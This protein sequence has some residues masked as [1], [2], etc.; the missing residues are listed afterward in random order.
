M[1][2]LISYAFTCQAA[3]HIAE[4][5][6][7]DVTQYALFQPPKE[8]DLG[9]VRIVMSVCKWQV[10]EDGILSAECVVNHHWPV[11]A[12]GLST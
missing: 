4:V 9:Q 11:A 3:K 2:L 5:T 6:D 12:R 7:T 1:M 10:A 8:L